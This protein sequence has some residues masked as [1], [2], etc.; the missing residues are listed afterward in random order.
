[1]STQN[2][3]RWCRNCQGL[4]FAGGGTQGVCFGLNPHD[5][6]ASAHY[7]MEFGDGD[8]SSQPQGGWRWCSICQGMHFAGGA[9]FEFGDG[10]RKMCFGKL[11]DGSLEMGVHENSNSGHYVMQF[12]D[13]GPNTQG[14]WRF[15]KKCFGLFFSGNTNQG[16]CPTGGQHDS[17]KSGHYALKTEQDI[18]IVTYD[19]VGSCNGY[20]QTTGPGGSGPQHSVNAGPNAAMVAF[21]AVNIDNSHNSRDYNFD[22]SRFFINQ[23]PRAFISTSLSMAKDLGV[24][25]AVPKVV[26]RGTVEGNNGIMVTTVSTVAANGASE[27]NNTNYFLIYDSKPGDPIV[28]LVKRNAGQTSFPQTDNCLAIQF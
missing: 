1:M 28:M 4:F 27:A 10:A 18:V 14:G 13:G 15:C 21:R 25:A 22:P 17:S 6:S 16:H 26:P 11:F 7:L 3:W 19:Q 5:G 8:A 2:G 20:N 12:G 24:F 9:I 23:E